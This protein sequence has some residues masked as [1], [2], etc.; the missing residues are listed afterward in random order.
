[1]NSSER[2]E[3]ARRLIKSGQFQEARHVL[4]PIRHEARATEWIQK[5]DVLLAEKKGSG[6]LPK[7]GFKMSPWVITATVALLAILMFLVG[8]VVGGYVLDLNPRPT[9][10]SIINTEHCCNHCNT[11]TSHGNPE[12]NKY[13]CT[14]RDT[15]PNISSHRHSRDSLV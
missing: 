6:R 1:M 2:Y 10:E 5:I 9:P 11:A 7:I 8:L 14:D 13:I 15:G 12:T 4:L 3:Q